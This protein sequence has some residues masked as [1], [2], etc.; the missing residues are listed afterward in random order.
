MNK[1]LV[2]GGTGAMGVYLVPE[3]LDKGHEVHVTSRSKRPSLD[4][5]LLYIHGNAQDIRFLSGLLNSGN[6][7]CIIDFMSYSTESFRQRIG[8]FLGGTGQYIYLSSYRV[9]ADNGMDAITE[10]SPRL[11]ETCKDKKY[12]RTDEYALAK[13]RQENMLRES[14]Y[15]NW[16]IVRPTITYSK[17]RF[18]LCTLEANT[19]IF[20]ALHKAPVVLPDVML[21]KQTTMTWAGDAARMI[22]GLVFKPSSLGEDFNVCTSEHNS[23]REVASIYEKAIGLK[24]IET[25]LKKYIRIVGGRYQILCDRMY[26]RIMDNT[27]I[28]NTLSLDRSN[29]VPLEKGLAKELKNIKEN[30]INFAF[31]PGINGAMDKITGVKIRPKEFPLKEK[32]VY[33]FSYWGI[34]EYIMPLWR[35]IRRIINVYR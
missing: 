6:Y 18:Q 33:H 7:D 31:G 13:A 15:R 24:I 17:N 28:I 19:V 22:A 35:I 10:N 23:W 8:L 12:L 11:L 32:I 27:K 14:E 16:T 1:I 4:P 5:G 21:N 34:I 25:S 9:F 20:R 30:G 3:L 26:N 29:I 2:L